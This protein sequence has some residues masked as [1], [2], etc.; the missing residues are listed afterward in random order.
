MG[1]RLVGNEAC[2]HLF[3]ISINCEVS[4]KQQDWVHQC[5]GAQYKSAHAGS[6]TLLLTPVLVNNSGHK[7]SSVSYAFAKK[8]HAVRCRGAA[9]TCSNNGGSS[10]CNTLLQRTLRMLAAPVIAA[11]GG[12]AAAAAAQQRAQGP[13]PA[14]SCRRSCSHPPPPESPNLSSSRIMSANS[15]L[16]GAEAPIARTKASH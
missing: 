15:P 8:H 9:Q 16:H 4:S 14:L 2:K 1:R 6:S 3:A 12:H 10:I 5:R 13:W 7:Q 11:P